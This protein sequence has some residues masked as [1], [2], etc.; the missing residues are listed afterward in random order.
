[1]LA[2]KPVIFGQRFREICL[3]TFSTS[4]S[5]T[6]ITLSLLKRISSN[7][8]CPR[9]LRAP[10]ACSLKLSNTFIV[11][12]C[13]SY[14]DDG[15]YTWRHNSVL[16]Y[17]AKSMSSIKNASLYADLPSFPSPSLITGD[18]LRPDL[19]FVLNN[20]TVY[21]LELTVG[22]ESNIKVNSERKAAKYHPLFTN[23]RTEYTNINFVNLSMSALGIYGTS[24][25][26]FLQML[27]DLNFNQNLTHQI[28]MKA[29]NIAIRCTYYIYCRRNKQWSNPELLQY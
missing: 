16:S 26:T 11:S 22:F 29:S 23:L 14:L 28:I 15:R 6:L 17:L 27:K 2:P 25:D 7:G 24:S 4:P 8:L 19:V 13:K 5:S 12:S 3:K 20:T 18:S 21:L 1:M 9:L 10:S